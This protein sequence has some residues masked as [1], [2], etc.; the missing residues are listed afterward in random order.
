MLDIHI[1]I[2]CAHQPLKPVYGKGRLHITYPQPKLMSYLP[3]A[4]PS[5]LTW[6]GRHP[7]DLLSSQLAAVRASAAAEAAAPEATSTA[8]AAFSV[9]PG[10]LE[11][12]QAEGPEGSPPVHEVFS[13]G[14]GAN[15]QL[16]TG[17]TGAQVLPAR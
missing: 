6:Q 15:Y 16:G 17:A 12:E 5:L 10:L 14:H 9:P 8:A 2:T 1:P 4:N 3:T 13:W 7:L 11:E